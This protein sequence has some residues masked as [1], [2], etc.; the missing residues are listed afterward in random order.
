M[1]TSNLPRPPLTGVRVLEFEALGPV[2]FAAMLLGQ[3]GAEVVRIVRPGSLAAPFMPG[4]D[5]NEIE[6]HRVCDLVLDLKRDDAR[7][8]VLA[9]LQ[10]HDVLIEGYRPGVMERLGLGPEPALL[11][12]PALVYGRM[13]GWGRHG[14]LAQRA[15]HDINYIGLTGALHAIGRRGEAPVPPLSLVGDY[16]GGAMFLVA[17][18]LAALVGTRGGS[19]GT[20]VDAAIVDGVTL[21]LASVW[22]RFAQGAWQDQRGC[23]LLDGG[24]PFYDTYRTRDARYMAVGALEPKFFDALSRALGLHAQWHAGNQ[25]DRAGWP[26]M[27]SAFAA[28]FG[29][30]TQTHWQTVFE[31]VDACVSPVLSLAEAVRHPQNISRGVHR[32][33]GEATLPSVA[34]RFDDVEHATPRFDSDN[35]LRSLH[36][37]TAQADHLASCIRRRN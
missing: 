25:L 35:W 1:P 33:E 18:V 24:A 36:L 13:T 7:A 29:S 8:L 11:A 27:R 5:C 14:P 26:A 16:G 2:P 32:R 15:G 34:P 12:Q 23:N 4:S 22:A 37:S 10:R 31:A 9:L 28:A 30:E 20:V 3:M 6:R 21:M 17:G 19:R